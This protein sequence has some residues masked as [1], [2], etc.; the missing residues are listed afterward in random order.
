MVAQ[1]VK[2]SVGIRRH[3]GDVSVTSELTDEDWLSSGSSVN[4][5][6]STSV[7]NVGS[8]SNRS[9]PGFDSTV[10]EVAA[11]QPSNQRPLSSPQLSALPRLV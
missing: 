9:A 8:F 10:T 3:P 2:Q 5:S 6:R 4:S 11:F 1:P 7:W